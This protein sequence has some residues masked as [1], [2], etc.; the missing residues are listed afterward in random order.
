MNKLASYIYY[1]MK[2]SDI[3][4]YYKIGKLD[5]RFG[6]WKYF[7][8]VLYIFE[9]KIGRNRKNL[10]LRPMT[11]FAWREHGLFPSKC[12]PRPRAIWLF[13]LFLWPFL[14]SCCAPPGVAGSPPW[15]C[16]RWNGCKVIYLGILT[17]IRVR[18]GVPW[19]T[20]F[21]CIKFDQ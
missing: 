15:S 1:F 12:R 16:P 17:T 9:K 6:G 8:F 10:P 2:L 14:W 7:R 20:C 11:W 5:E 21:A 19:T 3:I 13:P 4:F 18:L